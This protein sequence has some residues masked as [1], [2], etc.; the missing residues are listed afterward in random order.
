MKAE[1]EQR[2]ASLRKKLKQEKLDGLLIQTRV[3]SLYLS[4]FPS[5]NSLILVTQRQAIFF[6]DSR[7]IEKA[8]A[9]IKHLEVVEIVQRA[10]D[11]VVQTVKKLRVKQLGFE[12]SISHAE[13]LT[14]AKAL[15]GIAVLKPAGRLIKDL[16][17]VKSAAEVRQIAANQRLNEQLFLEAVDSVTPGDR[18]TDIRNRILH[19]LVELGSAE[20]FQAII[21]AGKNSALPHAVPGA[22][23]VKANNFLLFD[24]GVLKHHYHSDMT[25]TVAV[26]EKLP[27]NLKNIYEVTLEAQQA[28]LS[29]VAPGKSCKEIDAVARGIIADA[30][31]REYFGHGL[32]HGV[33]LE[34][35]EGPTLNPRSE[36]I[37]KPG[38]VITIEPGIYLPGKGGVRIEDLVVVTENG[39][40]NLTN[41]SK[42]L[43]HIL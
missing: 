36:D 15:Q 17:L 28:A 43:R 39:Y 23:R 13:Y 8:K 32:G 2:L 34:I 26:G 40:K 3:S 18:E 9:D 12:E 31:Y 20:A 37:L 4:G 19:R 41:V 29:A 11:G 42:Q 14:L 16:R 25:R 27:A 21:A 1:L 38:M 6:T 5:S 10:L 35:H 30:G 24:M 22:Q 33:G 7:Y